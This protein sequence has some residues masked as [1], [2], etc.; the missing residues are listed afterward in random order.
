MTVRTAINVFLMA[1]GLTALDQ[2]RGFLVMYHLVHVYLDNTVLTA[3][4]NSVVFTTV[5]DERDLTVG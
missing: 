5:S 2:I 4:D 3:R 1:F